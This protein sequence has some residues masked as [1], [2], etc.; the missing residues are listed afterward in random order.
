V[1]EVAPLAAADPR[2]VDSVGVPILAHRPLGSGA[3]VPDSESA[4][5]SN[6]L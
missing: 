2:E 6:P 4:E 1:E 5:G 3:S